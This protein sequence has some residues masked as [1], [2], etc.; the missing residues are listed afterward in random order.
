MYLVVGST[1]L[2][3]GEV[4]RQLVAKGQEVRALVRQTSDPAKVQALRDLGAEV[5]V[6]DA[7]DRGCLDA[8]CRGASAV[9]TTISSMPFSYQPG[10]TISEVDRDGQINLIDAAKA[11]GVGQF[12]Y[13]SF[14]HGIDASFPLKDAKLAVERHLVGSGLTYTILLPSYFMEVWLSPAVGF[15]AAGAK[16]A[17]YGDG[18]NPIS[19][20]SFV[21]VA[22]Y[23]VA[24]LTNPAAKNAKLELGGPEALSPLEVVKIYEEVGG[25]P[26][27]VQHV[28][29]AALA[30]QLEAATDGMQKSFAGLM[31]SYAHGSAIDVRE[32]QRVFQVQPTS[33]RDFA[34]RAL[35]G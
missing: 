13:T 27:E 30:G 31:L 5:V 24:S 11:A 14:T 35:G 9:V 28:P 15:D 8:A 33:V 3:G 10:N 34:R 19:W 20:I 26:F 6:G 21:D 18:R 29:E 22:R 25:R 1:G 32:T 16:A 23:A 4:C 2:L 12:A 17:I 7:R